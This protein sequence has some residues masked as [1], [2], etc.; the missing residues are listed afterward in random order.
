[1]SKV[2]SGVTAREFKK[3]FRGSV[4]SSLNLVPHGLRGFI[5]PSLPDSAAYDDYAG[6]LR[7]GLNWVIEPFERY[8]PFSYAALS[9]PGN[10]FLIGIGQVESHFPTDL[11][12]AFVALAFESAG[13]MIEV[14]AGPVSGAYEDGDDCFGVLL[15]LPEALAKSWL[16][17]ARSWR[18]PVEPYESFLVNRRLLGHPS[19]GWR[20]ADDYLDT[21]GR[22]WRKKFLPGIVEKFP[23]CFVPALDDSDCDRYRF[24][25]FLD[26]RPASISGPTG[27]Q[28]FV[29]STRRD[30]I[31]YHV[32]KG[33]V[34]N[35][36]V[37]HDPADAIDR[38]SAHVLRNLPGEFDFSP[39]SEPY[40]E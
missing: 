36:R 38:Y 31:V 18:I 40:A 30:Q 8:Q 34:A 4:Y 17:R 20:R 22:G 9:R 16:W 26:T 37:L 1:M 11:P 24:D 25:C 2:A 29:V 3:F 14:F 10:D 19:G 7:R 23:D 39:W 32:H 33:D 35:L 27:D 12:S 6:L 15:S 21:L 5:D 28:F 13:R